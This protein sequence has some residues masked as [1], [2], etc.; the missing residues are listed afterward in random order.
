MFLEIYSVYKKLASLIEQLLAKEVR[1]FFVELYEKMGSK[2]FGRLPTW[3]QHINL[4]KFPTMT[5]I[6]LSLSI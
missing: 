4:H 3:L 5:L 6:S 2:A 1:L